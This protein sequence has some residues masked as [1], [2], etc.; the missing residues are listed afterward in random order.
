MIYK[1]KIKVSTIRLVNSELNISLLRF[2][3][4][5]L[6][7]KVLPGKAEEIFTDNNIST[8]WFRRR[9]KLGDSFL[10]SVRPLK[11][12]V[13]SNNKEG[14]LAANTIRSISTLWARENRKELQDNYS[15]A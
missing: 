8:G 9:T 15:A 6:N 12:V 4:S 14:N 3:T 13:I 11:C 5:E 7:Y 2:S 1:D 10:F